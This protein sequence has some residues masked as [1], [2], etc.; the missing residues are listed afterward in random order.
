MFLLHRYELKLYRGNKRIDC[1]L[2]NYL[3]AS[4]REV[5]KPRIIFF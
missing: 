1:L 5:A 4:I 2:L 3:V